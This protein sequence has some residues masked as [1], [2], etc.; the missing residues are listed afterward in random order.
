MA[1][2]RGRPTKAEQAAKQALE[3]DKKIVCLNCGCK[4]Q[5]LFYRS[6]NPF[7]KF[8]GY[9]PYCKDCIKGEMW[10]FY[11]KKYDNNEHIALH[12]LLRSLN[13]PY[14]HSIYLASLKNINNPNAKINNVSSETNADDDTP[15]IDT[16]GTIISAY[17]KT[18]NSFYANN[19]YGST[20][21]DSEGVDEISGVYD[22]EP[23]ITIKRR[24]TPAPY[25]DD[26]KDD[27]RYEYIEYN[28]EELIEKWGEFDDNKLKKLEL[29]YLDWQ[30]KIGDC[31]YEKSTDL[32]VKQV[33]FLTITIQ[34]K[35]VNG[36]LADEEM[37]NLRI[38]LK[39]SGLLEK[40]KSQNIESTVIGMTIRDIEQFRPIKETLPELVDVDNYKEIEDTFI[41]AMSR[42]LGKE[43]EFT[44]KFDE[45]YKDYTIDIVEGRAPDGTEQENPD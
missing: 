44:R 14:I 4:N 9:I 19:G 20:Y 23:N 29:E 43:N 37:K 3:K 42:T 33:C 26:D 31:I 17:M 18:Y 8:F 30:D 38:M 10:K 24:R 41:G 16:E 5:A 11:L 7:N 2:T 1:G 15:A 13:L 45:I 27:E 40:Q 28:A 25:S 36:D 39:E 32:M 34:E 35:R 6:Q 21:L 22:Y 12:A